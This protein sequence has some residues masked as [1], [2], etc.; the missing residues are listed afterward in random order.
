[1]NIQESLIEKF[2]NI[3]LKVRA[4][5]NIFLNF[6]DGFLTVSYCRI[7]YM[8]KIKLKHSKFHRTVPLSYSMLKNILFGIH[9]SKD[10][11]SIDNK[12]KEN[13]RKKTYFQKTKKEIEYFKK[14]K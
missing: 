14:R 9:Y 13:E 7:Q 12:K 11:L 2:R 3:E 6:Q 10:Y 4:F 8:I 1:V 5:M